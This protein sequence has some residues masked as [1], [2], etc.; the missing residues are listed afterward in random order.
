MNKTDLLECLPCP[1]CGGIRIGI[2]ERNID[3]ILS[4]KGVR[5]VDCGGGIE[6]IYNRGWQAVKQWNTRHKKP[7]QPDENHH[8]E[9]V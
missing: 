5:C 9:A 4:L 6:T 2:I 3:M 1:F 8:L 7:L